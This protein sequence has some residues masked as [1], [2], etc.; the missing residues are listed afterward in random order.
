MDNAKTESNRFFCPDHKKGLTIEATA[1]IYCQTGSHPLTSE[2]PPFK[3]YLEYCCGCRRFIP[4]SITGNDKEKKCPSCENEIISR[5]FCHNCQTLTYDV[6]KKLDDKQYKI[7]G[8]G[9]VAPHCPACKMNSKPDSFHFHDCGTLKTAFH[10]SRLRCSFCLINVFQTYEAKIRKL[11]ENLSNYKSPSVDD[12]IKDAIS[13]LTEEVKKLHHQD[14]G[15]INYLKQFEPKLKE[16]NAG[17]LNEINVIAKQLKN[18]DNKLDVVANNSLPG[19]RLSD[20]ENEISSKPVQVSEYSSLQGFVSD[21]HN[22]FAIKPKLTKHTYPATLKPITSGSETP[23]YYGIPINHKG[24]TIVYAVPAATR[25]Q[26]GSEAIHLSD[27][28]TLQQSNTSALNGKLKIEEPAEIKWNQK[29]NG[30]QLVYKGVI[31]I[32]N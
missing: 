25:I 32:E 31:K 30:W 26:S 29:I 10:T 17:K 11:E 19:F 1:E 15:I 18:L 3:E 8:N 24:G 2:F 16:L 9:D 23:T 6:V 21:V 5:Y 20:Y 12:S 4:F 7:L 14:N 22:R 13:K 28:Y 27:F